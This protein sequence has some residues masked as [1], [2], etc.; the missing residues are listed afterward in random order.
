MRVL[1]AIDLS[2][3]RC[4]RLT[5]GRFDSAIS[6]DG[7]P[8]EVALS[9]QRQGASMIHVV[10][11]DGARGGER[12]VHWDLAGEMAA[13]LD[14]PVQFGGGIRSA[15]DVRDLLGRGVGRVVVGTLAVRDPQA[16]A[17]LLQES[18]DRLVIGLDARD[19]IV[20]V[21]GWQETSGRKATDLAR[22]LASLGARR[23]LYT[24][25][26]R[27]GTLTGPNVE[28]TRQLALAAGVRV[29]A[30]GGV[31]QLSDLAALCGA[32]EDGVD[33]VVVGKALY[34]GRF[35]LGEA[36]SAVRPPGVR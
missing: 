19:G 21:S 5:E 9:W 14:I 8:L 28:A 30:S 31:S 12:T 11:L 10:D 35:T 4:V 3:G 23:F 1:P 29:T 16:I 26:A 18:A 2:G 27:D 20:L 7:D 15:A 22:D 32:E 36:L 17:G 6:Y 13:R 24:D 33:E 25:V 34:E